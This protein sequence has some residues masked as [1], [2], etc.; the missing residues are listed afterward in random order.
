MIDE[1]VRLGGLRVVLVGCQLAHDLLGA[2][3]PP[4]VVA[5]AASDRQVAGIVRAVQKRLTQGGYNPRAGVRANILIRERASDQMRY[6]MNVA[7]YLTVPSLAA[8]AS[9]TLPPSLDFLHYV[10]YP[11]RLAGQRLKKRRSYHRT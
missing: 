3:V 4:E 7:R 11:F 6:V 2:P 9:L 1:G 8:R 5:R 10:L